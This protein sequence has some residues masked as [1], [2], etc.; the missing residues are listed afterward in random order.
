MS[1]RAAPLRALL[2]L[3]LVA[4]L[5]GCAV[6]GL[7]FV[8]DERVTLVSPEDNATVSLPFALE[9]SVRDY[10]G[11][12]AV[13]FDRSPMRPGQPLRALVPED[14]P[15]H[16]EPECPD[17]QWL[18]SNDVYITDGTRLVIERLPDLRATER[19]KDRHDVSIVLLDADGRRLGESVFT[20]EFIVERE[21]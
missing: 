18:A 13:V 15:C 14:D 10:D 7:S 3:A 11:R 1:R 12:F 4:A 2:A 19:A 8:A 16:A 20:R 21:D 5:P 9:W 17:A 6:K